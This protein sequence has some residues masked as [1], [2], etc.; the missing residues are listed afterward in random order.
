MV[1]ETYARTD[2]LGTAR[3]RMGRSGKLHD[4]PSATA[5]ARDLLR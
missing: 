3:K 4:V 5:A 2:V 1:V